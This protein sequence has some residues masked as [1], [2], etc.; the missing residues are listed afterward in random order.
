MRSINSAILEFFL[1]RYALMADKSSILSKIIKSRQIVL[2]KVDNSEIKAWEA[3]HSLNHIDCETDIPCHS[4]HQGVWIVAYSYTISIIEVES[5]Y[6]FHNLFFFPQQSKEDC[7]VQELL[8][9]FREG[10]LDTRSNKSI[11]ITRNT[12]T[13]SEPFFENTKLPNVIKIFLY[14]LL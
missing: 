13:E 2:I 12:M 7:F 10:C 8:L 6:L 11:C 14:D 4:Q 9:E 5:L 1:I 3:P